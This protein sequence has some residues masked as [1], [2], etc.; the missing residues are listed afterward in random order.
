MCGVHVIE[1]FLSKRRAESGIARIGIR[2]A[3]GACVVLALGDV[4][5]LTR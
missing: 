4:F 1:T 3:V 5:L 2:L